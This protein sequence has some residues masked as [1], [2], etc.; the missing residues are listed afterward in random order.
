MKIRVIKALRALKWQGS[1]L[2]GSYKSVL[3]KSCCSTSCNIGQDSELQEAWRWPH[4]LGKRYLR[5]FSILRHYLGQNC[6]VEHKWKKLRMAKAETCSFPVPWKHAMQAVRIGAC[7]SHS[8]IIELRRN[9][10][11]NIDGRRACTHTKLKHIHTFCTASCFE[12]RYWRYWSSIPFREGYTWQGMR[13]L[14]W[15]CGMNWWESCQGC[16]LPEGRSINQDNYQS[17]FIPLL[18]PAPYKCACTISQS[19]GD[20]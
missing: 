18:R 15:P 17:S 2:K 8:H 20:I 1:G 3:G 12:A 5:R 11:V 6:L 16:V 4:L 10:L 19:K 7:A 14:S 9:E 13:E